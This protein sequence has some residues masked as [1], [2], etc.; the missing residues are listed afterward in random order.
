MKEN[1]L[2]LFHPLIHDSNKRL[3]PTL[4]Q[5]YGSRPKHHFKPWFGSRTIKHLLSAAAYKSSKID[6]IGRWLGLLRS[7]NNLAGRIT[8]QKC[9][10]TGPNL[11]WKSGD[12]LESRMLP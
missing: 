2:D 9:F 10:L 4:F 7:R 5:C 3:Y 1:I 6:I 8:S 11:Y 12:V